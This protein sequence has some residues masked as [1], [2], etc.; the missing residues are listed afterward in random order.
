[1]IIDVLLLIVGLAVL[2]Y[3]GD[4]LVNGSVK[5][6]K[7]FSISPLIIGMTIVAFGT[8]APEL[9]VSIKASLAGSSEI[10]IGNVIGSNIANLALVLGLTALIFPL[11]IENQS[12]R[13][14]WP[15]M[16]FASGLFYLFIL[17]GEIARWEG[18]VLFSILIAFIIFLLNIKKTNI[19]EEEKNNAKKTSITKPIFLVFAGLLGLYFG[20]EW[21][22]NGAVN[23]AK[24]AGISE[25]VIGVTIIAFGTSVPELATSAI[26]A[27]KKQADISI[28]NLIGSNIFN[29]LAVIGLTGIITPIPVSEMV[30]NFDVFWVIG[31]AFVLFPLMR[32]GKIITRTKGI[33]LLTIY[34]AYILLLL[35]H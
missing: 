29:I 21:L 35:N 28:G 32:Y 5:I 16:M 27:F 22:L 12:L 25:H 1:M 6:A 23:I 11:A 14:D 4:L 8:S 33:F 34:L 9:I 3:G 13:I 7:H 17:D 30:I 24:K 26:A 18:I 20:S 15:M 19:T 10:A 2:I 31:I